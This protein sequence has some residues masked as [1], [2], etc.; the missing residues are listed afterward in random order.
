MLVQ[1]KI[2]DHLE[3]EY[4]TILQVLEDKNDEYYHATVAETDKHVYVSKDA[5]EEI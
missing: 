3:L 5:V 4:G 2:K 1:I